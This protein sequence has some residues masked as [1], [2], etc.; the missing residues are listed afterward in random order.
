VEVPAPAADVLLAE[1]L[2][3]RI[4]ILMGAKGTVFAYEVS[5][6][7]GRVLTRRALY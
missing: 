3:E 2:E 1:A 7:D 4:R 6:K 5:L